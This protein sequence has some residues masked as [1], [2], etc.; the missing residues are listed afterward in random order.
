[1][2]ENTEKKERNEVVKQRNRK[3]QE[4]MRRGV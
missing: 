1:M 2:G 4:N 3:T